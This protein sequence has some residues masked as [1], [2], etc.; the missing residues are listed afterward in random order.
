MPAK[1]TVVIGLGNALMGDD[2]IGLAILGRLQAHWSFPS[3]VVFV[4]GGTWGMNLLPSIE[5]AR[6]VLFLD[7]VDVGR[8]PGTPVRLE[9]ER[10]PR[11]LGHKLSAHQIDLK[12]VLAVAELRGTLPARIVVVGIQP[13]RVDLGCGLS[14][15][16]EVALDRAAELARNTLERWGYRASRE[17]GAAVYA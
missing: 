8:E 9:R 7:A 2:G 3:N 5:T 13:S 10:I 16:V 1:P 12:E 14:P 15:E 17:E 4:D 6:E 11:W